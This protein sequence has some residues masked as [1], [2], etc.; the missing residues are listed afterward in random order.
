MQKA[1]KKP[2]PH[3]PKGKTVKSPPVRGAKW[4]RLWDHFGLPALLIAFL[5]CLLFLLTFYQSLK[6]LT[7]FACLLS[8]ALVAFACRKGR[9]RQRFQLPVLAGAVYFLIVAL[10]VIWTCAGKF[11]LREYAKLLLVLPL[12]LFVTLYVPRSRRAV[13]NLLLVLCSASA[14]YALLGVD[15]ASARLTWPLL[16]RIPGVDPNSLAYVQDRLPGIF[17]NSNISGGLQGFAILLT[18]ALF[19]RSQRRSKNAWAAFLCGIQIFCF[20]LG[21]NR[22]AIAFLAVSMLVVFACSGSGRTAFFW[23]AVLTVVPS[24]GIALLASGL[25]PSAENPVVG[26]RL[27]Y[28]LLAMLFCGGLCAALEYVYDTVAG[29]TGGKGAKRMPILILSLFLVAAAALLSILLVSTP[30]TV[31][32][33]G[34]VIRAAYPKAGE[35]RLELQADGDVRV[36]I[37]SSSFEQAA[38]FRSTALYEGD[39]SEA[40]FTVGADARVVYFEFRADA[41]CTLTDAVAVGAEKTYRIHL[42]YPLLP[43]MIS[44]RLIGI[45]A[46]HN[47]TERFLFFRDGLRIFRDY[48]VF[49]AGLG[50]F[51]SLIAGYQGHRYVTRYAHNHYVQVLVDNGILGFLAYLFLLLSCLLCI[52]RGRRK[53]DPFH[54]RFAPLLGAF[55]M[56]ALQTFMDVLMSTMAYLPFAYAFFGLCALCWG[57]PI[58]KKWAAITTQAVYALIS[59]AYALLIVLNIRANALVARSSYSPVRFFNALESALRMDVFEDTDWK[60]SYLAASAQLDAPEYQSRAD[61]FAEELLDVPSNSLHTHLVSYYLQARDYDMALRAA[62]NGA[63]FNYADAETWDQYFRAFREASELCPEDAGEIRRIMREFYASFETE[64]ARM[65]DPISLNEESLAWVEAALRD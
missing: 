10:S 5:F 22:S 37:T 49:G 65:Y 27:A 50:A 17:A 3:D 8:A 41:D 58:P 12:F 54:E 24:A 48:P 36:S 21:M 11:F 14:I 63:H 61:E 57:R 35:Y 32:A 13:Y 53:D 47:L 25:F 44:E 43:D 9:F 23:R 59:L 46:T 51:E 31:P 39:A 18:Y 6:G 30:L 15:L 62:Q 1:N 33:G 42:G 2:L 64:I 20:V 16:G 60:V 55:V 38:S 52:L 28:P 45:W 7:A 34:S 29:K 4:D 26:F 56:L 19:G 40:I